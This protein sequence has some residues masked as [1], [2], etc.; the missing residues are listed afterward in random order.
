MTA[1]QTYNCFGFIQVASG[2]VSVMATV[3]LENGTSVN[4][5]FTQDLDQ[6]IDGIGS[7]EIGTAVFGAKLGTAAG[8]EVAFREVESLE[9]LTIADIKE[10]GQ[11][12]NHVFKMVR[13]GA[14]E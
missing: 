2:A 10:V 14:K 1:L 5:T 13:Q 11:A 4:R 3:V 7:D 9:N 6:P 8:A 12:L